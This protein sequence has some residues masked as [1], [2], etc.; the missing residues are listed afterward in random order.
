MGRASSSVFPDAQSAQLL[1]RRAFVRALGVAAGAVALGAALPLSGCAPAGDVLRVGTKVDVPGFGFQNPE[2]GNVEGLEVDVA[3][4]LAARIKGDENAL[5]LVGVNATTRGAMLDN[6]ALDAALATFT[7]T[8]DRRRS[9]DFSRPYY[10][11]YI[12]VLVKKD[13]GIADLADLDGKTVGVALSATTKDKLREAADAIGITLKFAEYATYPE[14]KIALVVGRVDAFSVDRSILLGYQ[15]DTTQLLDTQFAPQEYGVATAKGSALTAPVDEAIAAM[16]ADGTLAALKE[17][18]GL[19]LATEA[20]V[21]AEQAAGGS[22]LGAGDPADGADAADAPAAATDA[23]ADVGVTTPDD[24]A[25]SDGS[26]AAAS[27]GGGVR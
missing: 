1:T 3:R 12:G 26:A 25:P 19:S 14:I 17:R 23:G 8:E 16:E 13:A 22:G 11:D 18:W 15:D 24:A 20:D 10:I 27:D 2:T 9:Y 6:G 21:E 4:E 7:I 5:E